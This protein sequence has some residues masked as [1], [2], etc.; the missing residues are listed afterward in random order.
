MELARAGMEDGDLYSLAMRRTMLVQHEKGWAELQWTGE[1]QLSR[2][3][4]RQHE[5]YGNVLAQDTLNK[6]TI[7]FKRLQSKSRNIEG[8]DWSVDI[9]EYRML[10]FGIDPAQELLIILESPRWSVL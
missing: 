2:T 6:S 5:L 1:H 8:K 4:G 7:H 9:R 10:V 3:R